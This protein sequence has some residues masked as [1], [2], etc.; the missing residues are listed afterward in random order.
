MHTLLNINS[1]FHSTIFIYF[2]FSLRG[3]MF[4]LVFQSK[5]VERHFNDLLKRYG[6]CIVVDLT[7]KVRYTYTRLMPPKFQGLDRLNNV[8]CF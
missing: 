5:V 3:L 8:S 6:G 2:Y 4:C 7:D 1:L